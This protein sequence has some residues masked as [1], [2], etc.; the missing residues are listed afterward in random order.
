MATPSSRPSTSF[1]EAET[2]FSES[3]TVDADEWNTIDEPVS[4]G[5]SSFLLEYE[6]VIAEASFYQS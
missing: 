2:Q 4:L 3:E 6:R 1:G 5:L